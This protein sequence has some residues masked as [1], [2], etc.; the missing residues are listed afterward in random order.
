MVFLAEKYAWYEWLCHTNFSFLIGASHPLDY[1]KRAIEFGYRGLSITDYDGVYGIARAYRE[2]QK[3]IQLGTQ[4]QLKLHYGAEIHFSID[5][6][7]PIYYQ[8]TLVLLAQSH[9]GY[10]NLCRLLSYAHRGGKQDANIPIED[11]LT[12][13]VDGLVAIQPMRGFIRRREGLDQKFMEQHFGL[14]KEKFEGNLFF[15]ISRHLNYAEDQWIN[16][17][18]QLAKALNCRLLLSQDVYFH[19]R[20]QKRLSD[21]LHAIRHNRTL[22]K[23][24]DHCFVNSRRC[25]HSLS[26][27]EKLYSALPFYQSSLHHALELSDSF[28]FELNQLRYQYPKEMLPAG[29][30][31]QEFLEKLTWVNS[32]KVYGN[33]LPEK[34]HHILSH[35]LQLVEQL[36]FADYFLTVYDIVSWARSKEILCQGRGSAA[37]SAICFVLGITSVN[38]DQFDLLFERF[39][40]IERGDPPDIDVDFEHERREEV[41]QY[42][43]FRY[44]REKAAMVCNVICFKTRGA[45]RFTGKALGIPEVILSRGAKI[46]DSRAYRWS[47][48]E[49]TVGVVKQELDAG[50]KTFSIPDHIWRL[51]GEFAQLLRGFPRHLGI[52]SGGFILSDK[53]IDWLCPQEPASMEGRTVVEWCKE[54]IEG[55]GFFKIDI[56]ALGMLTALRKCFDLIKKHYGYKLSLSAIRADDP[57]TYKMIQKADTV[58]VFQIESRAQMSF[59]PRHKPQKFY[60]LVVQVAIIRPGP[61]QGGMIHPYLR[62]RFG[63]EPIQ[64]PDTRLVPILKRTYGVPIFQEQVMRVAMSVGGFTP[65][66]ANELRKNIGSFSLVGNVDLW[67]TKL[68]DGMRRNGIDEQFIKGIMEQIKGF[69]S[70]GFPESHAAS[71]ALLAYASSYLKCH[72]PEAFFTAILNSQPMG[73]YSPDILLK[74][75]AHLGV[76][77]LPICVVNS[78]WDHCLEPIKA[79]K[80]PL[81]YAI[82]L[83]MRLIRG[84]NEKGAKQLIENRHCSNGWS[85]LEEMLRSCQLTR[86]DLTALAAANTLQYYGIGR[87]A[88]I[89]LAEAAPFCDLVEAPEDP[90]S[91]ELESDLEAV[92]LDYLSSST[93]L[94]KH[95]TELMKSTAWSYNVPEKALTIARQVK[96]MKSNRW[97]TV[98]GMVTCRQAP[99]TA[100]GMCFI[101]LWDESGSFDLVVRPNIYAK[102]RTLLDHTAFICVSGVLQS[103]QDA[104]SILVSTVHA[105]QTKRAEVIHLTKR[106][107]GIPNKVGFDGQE[108]IKSR[109]YM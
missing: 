49:E 42:I 98:F 55:L 80:V 102:F 61:I 103:N 104:R 10:Y 5:H 74:T 11:L 6:H 94:G 30:S 75:A 89:W 34:M 4:T 22:D 45:L 33:P 63:M 105:P 37:N 78:E 23:V 41:I 60:D 2:L 1:I 82:R 52:H 69:S 31:P 39:I 79:E 38:P 19:D 53:A 93:S 108:Y 14:L 15:V 36:K 106:K 107:R 57:A 91:F 20:S 71:F 77:V 109:N 40:S 76:K 50:P 3:L 100:K 67:L 58:G 72:F 66:E 7:L 81:K 88:A 16:P 92:Q 35:E 99:P 17:T 24:T 12:F 84:L 25:L 101:T 64:F 65:G 68:I 32:T 70:Y 29:Y 9:Q 90:V 51:W 97:I 43:Y 83:G 59:L 95:P 47:A 86:I 13:Q 85:S 46:L 62:R 28:E 44:G 96:T 8:N 73:F 26:S 21:L 54:D 18:I 27:L 56:L 48:A 87:K